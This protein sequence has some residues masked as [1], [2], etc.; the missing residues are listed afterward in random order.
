MPRA[1]EQKNGR[2]E[3]ALEKL[4]Q[5]QANMEQRHALLEQRDAEL[6][7]SHAEL[8]RSVAQLNQ[9]IAIMNQ[10]QANYLTQ[11]AETDRQIAETNRI[12]WERFL[13][14]EATLAKIFR[15]IQRLPEAVRE[16]IG[17]KSPPLCL[18]SSSSGMCNSTL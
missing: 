15:M 10:T 14:I 1:K 3:A 2:L 7:Q 4:A 9:S 16:K 11:K 6:K 18:T 13:R 5:S 8:E 12:N 17:F